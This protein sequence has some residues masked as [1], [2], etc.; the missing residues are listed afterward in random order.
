LEAV[1]TIS[2]KNQRGLARLREMAD[3]IGEL[4]TGMLA[5]GR[6]LPSFDSKYDDATQSLTVCDGVAYRFNVGDC[7]YPNESTGLRRVH[8]VLENDDGRQIAFL[9]PLTFVQWLRYLRC[10]VTGKGSV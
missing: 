1:V 6:D 3:S 4:P 10:R 9:R 7:L 2:P 8:H 5:V